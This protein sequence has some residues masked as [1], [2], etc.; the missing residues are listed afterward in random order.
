MPIK[1]T[2]LSISLYGCPSESLEYWQNSTLI[3][4][5]IDKKKRTFV[6]QKVFETVSI[7]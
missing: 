1:D 3:Y 2:I 4:W 5:N 6:E 7:A